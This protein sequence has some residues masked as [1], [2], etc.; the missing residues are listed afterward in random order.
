MSSKARVRIAILGALL[1]LGVISGAFAQ[2]E[3]GG[4]SIIVNPRP[5]DLRVFVSVDRDPSGRGNPVYMI[6]D[7][8]AVTVSVT[9]D[10][11]VYVFSIHADGEI[12]LILPNRLSENPVRLRGGQS[13]TLPRPG[14]PFSLTV[15]GPTGLN[16]VL[17]LASHNPLSLD[18]LAGIDGDDVRGANALGADGLARAL[19]IIVEP[20]PGDRWATATAAFTVA[21]L[22][23]GFPRLPAVGG[24]LSVDSDPRGAQVLVNG[25]PRGATPVRIDLPVGTY[26]VRLRL[27]GFEEFVSTVTIRPGQTSSVMA[28]LTRVARQGTLSVTSSPLGALVWIDGSPVGATPLSVGLAPGQ[29]QV[30]VSLHGHEDFVAAVTV[31]AG[32]IAR[33]DAQLRLVQRTGTLQVVASVPGAEVWL[34]G[35]RV[36]VSPLSLVLAEGIHLV[37]VRA[38]G[39]AEFRTQVTIRAGRTTTVDAELRQLTGVLRIIGAP[40]G[41][42]VFVD[43]FAIGR[44]AGGLLNVSE[45]AAGMREVTVIAPGFRTSISQVNV[46]ADR[47]TDL[48]VALRPF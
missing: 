21:G 12:V 20:L 41:A 44:V 26:E 34:G 33:I 17:A 2:P 47:R 24:V 36:G 25:E 35:T 30:R 14:D 22:A 16:R 8:I 28:T 6:G 1:A 4:Q 10:S 3:I 29:Y 37:Q 9:R 43:G 13:R 39:F 31:R 38:A 27:P 23:P 7:S 45:I 15:A 32:Q 19:S 5:G 11:Y 48:R 18:D 40:D 46:I 42:Y